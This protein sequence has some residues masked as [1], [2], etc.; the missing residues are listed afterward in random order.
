MREHGAPRSTIELIF[1]PEFGSA[2]AGKVV[3]VTGFWAQTMLFVVLTYERTGSAAWVGAVTAAQLLPQLCLALLSGSMADKRGPQLPIVSGGICSGLGC[4][5]LALWIGIPQTANAVPVQIPLLTASAVSGI[6]IALASSAMQAVPP[7]LSAPSERARA[8][9]LNFLPTALARTLGPIAGA[10]LASALGSVP[11]LAIVGGAC[12]G[13]AV[14][15]LFI[16]RLGSPGSDTA[17]EHR[18]GGVV[19]YLRADRPL[20]AVLSG[21]A[22]IGVGSESAITLAPPLANVLGIGA[23]GAGWVTGAFGVGGL[24]GVVGFRVCSRYCRPGTA[25]CLAM[26]LLGASM[27]AIGIAPSLPFATAML[28][29]AGASMV[30]GITAFSIIV[31]QRSPAAFLGRVMAVWI[32]A[33]SGIRPLAGLALGFASDHASTL[34]AVIGAGILTVGGTLGVRWGLGEQRRSPAELSQGGGAPTLTSSG[35]GPHSGPSLDE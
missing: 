27:T 6:G 21:V 22:V 3:L 13:A 18:L 9:S 7:R 2:L 35:R 30:T 34:T 17:H 24:V 11:T 31:Q 32:M 10:G 8:M 14:I 12:L 20:L 4:I 5:G 28:V 29:V 1:H 19:R 15:F 16:R 26:F 33:F 25:G 23:P